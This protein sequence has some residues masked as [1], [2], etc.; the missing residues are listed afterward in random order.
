MFYNLTGNNA[1]L[2]NVSDIIDTFVYRSMIQTPVSYTH[3]FRYPDLGRGIEG[4]MADNG[5]AGKVL[6]LVN[7]NE[8]K[9]QSQFRIDGKW[10]Y[11]ELLPESISTILV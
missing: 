8:E 7:P 5:E 3:L 10:W 4:F 6:V 11:A 9:V 1:L 2:Y